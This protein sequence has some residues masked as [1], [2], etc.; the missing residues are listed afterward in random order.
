MLSMDTTIALQFLGL[1][2]LAISIAGIARTQHFVKASDELAHSHMGIFLLSTVRVIIGLVLT[3]QP[4]MWGS[5]DGTIAGF[6]GALILT[7]GMFGLIF[8]DEIM[9]VLPAWTKSPQRTRAWLFI[10]FVAGAALSLFGF[11]VL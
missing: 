4:G 9:R 11:G 6:F 8:P 1:F 5:L 7:I 10:G 2:F 3:L